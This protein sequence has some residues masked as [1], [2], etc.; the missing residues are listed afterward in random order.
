[1][2]SPKWPICIGDNNFTKEPLH[3]KQY[4]GSKDPLVTCMEIYTVTQK[5]NV[6]IN[7]L[8]LHRHNSHFNLFF[9]SHYI[10]LFLNTTLK[11]LSL[12]NIKY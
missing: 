9:Y 3:V 11:F 10:S 1:M 8:K 2:T 12:Q 6:L 7:P 4:P 5:N